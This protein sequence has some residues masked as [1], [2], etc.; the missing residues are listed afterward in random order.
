VSLAPTRVQPGP[1]TVGSG[2]PSSVPPSQVERLLFIEARL[3][4]LGELRRLDVTSRFSVASVQASRDIALYKQ[5]AP[6]NLEYDYHKKT[7]LPSD[8]FQQVFDLSAESVLWWLKFGLG[9]GIPHPQG[10]VTDMVPNLALPSVAQLAQVTRAIYRKRA[11]EIRYLSLSSGERVRQIVPHALVDTGKRW[12]VRAYDR[13]N[14]RFSDFVLNRISDAIPLTE[15]GS[16]E[17]GSDRDEQWQRFLDLELVPHPS[18]PHKAAI[19]ADYGMKNGRRA[20]RCRAAL[21]GYV[22][23]HWSVDCSPTHSL[24]C[25]EYQL[26]LANPLLLSGVNNAELAPGVTPGPLD[27]KKGSK[28]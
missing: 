26:W 5:L 28:A 8:S 19:E 13:S 6:N 21:A 2:V 24:P 27:R 23:R 14:A 1:T 22:L 17:E 3:L 10:F 9:D 4:F 11:L 7:Y 12:H 15:G 16:A 20:L 18:L 25:E